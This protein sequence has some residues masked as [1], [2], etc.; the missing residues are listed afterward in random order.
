VISS[1]GSRRTCSERCPLCGTRLISSRVAVGND[2]SNACQLD[3]HDYIDLVTSDRGRPSRNCSLDENLAVILL[4][5][6]VPQSVA[7]VTPEFDD[8][9]PDQSSL[10]MWAGLITFAEMP[11]VGRYRLLIEEFEYVSANF[12]AA[13]SRADFPKRLIYAEIFELAA[14][15]ISET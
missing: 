11:K 7:K 1:L 14:A 13:G 2:F 12:A 6:T 9:V 3:F 5:R 8:F 15:L 10:A 4:G